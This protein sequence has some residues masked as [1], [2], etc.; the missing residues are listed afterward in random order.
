M[1]E[2]QPNVYRAPPPAAVGRRFG[3]VAVLRAASLL[4]AAFAA[5]AAPAVGIGLLPALLLVGCWRARAS[6][7][8][9]TLPKRRTMTAA[10]RRAITGTSAAQGITLVG[11]GLLVFAVGHYEWWPVAVVAVSAAHLSTVAWV[12]RRVLDAVAVP[13]AWLAAIAGAVL[14]V[15]GEWRGAWVV[16]CGIMCLVTATYARRVATR[17]VSP[18]SDE[19]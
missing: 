11:G 15:R 7:L 8:P 3:P 13:A 19:Q 2:V 18:R 6:G 4:Y 14:V 17:E 1:L 9:G 5:A 12:A 16:A 10:R